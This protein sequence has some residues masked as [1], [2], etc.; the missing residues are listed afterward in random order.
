MKIKA[1]TTH[2]ATT[3]LIMAAQSAS[4]ATAGRLSCWLK[5]G[6]SGP[7]GGS[8]DGPSQRAEACGDAGWGRCA[9][10]GWHAI[11]IRT[12]SAK[13][14]TTFRVNDGGHT[15]EPVTCHRK[16]PNP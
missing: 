4:A 1:A 2:R 12:A 10:G 5:K 13:G 16:T 7:R 9:K 8:Q 14:Q 6:P 15:R 11:P 3:F